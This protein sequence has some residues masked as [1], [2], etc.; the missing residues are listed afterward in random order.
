MCQLLKAFRIKKIEAKIRNSNMSKHEKARL[1][2]IFWLFVI[3]IY[4]HI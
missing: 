1:V 4:T 3:V 2:I